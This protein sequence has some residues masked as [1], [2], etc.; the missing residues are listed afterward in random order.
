[1]KYLR[2]FENINF[3]H[4][5][6]IIRNNYFEAALWTEDYDD[7]LDDKTIYDFSS[8]AKEQTNNEIIWFVHT[9]GDILDEIPDENIGH[10]LWLTRNEHGAGFSDREYDDDIVEILNELSKQLGVVYLE[11]NDDKVDIINNSNKFKDF[12]IEK[13]KEELKLN[14]SSKK[15][16]L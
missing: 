8:A 14:R 15:Y 2:Y 10:D 9:S 7:D 1:M 3:G 4:N 5:I 16:N 12:D 13:Y 6:D 11:V